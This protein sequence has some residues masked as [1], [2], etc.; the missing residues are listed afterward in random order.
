VECIFSTL[1]PSFMDF[2]G[3]VTTGSVLNTNAKGFLFVYIRSFVNYGQTRLRNFF[4]F[5]LSDVCLLYLSDN[6]LWIFFFGGWG[7]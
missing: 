2:C 5:D 1:N 3:Y 4:T 7:G 6:L